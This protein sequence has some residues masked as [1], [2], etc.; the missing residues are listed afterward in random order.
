MANSFPFAE[1]KPEQAKHSPSIS[2]FVLVSSF[3]LVILSWLLFYWLPAWFVAL[4]VFPVLLLVSLLCW[5]LSRGWLQRWRIQT[6]RRGI[7]LYTL[8]LVLLTVAAPIYAHFYGIWRTRSFIQE[9]GLDV[10]IESQ[11]I[12]LLDTLGDVAPYRSVTTVY[13]LLEPIENAEVKIRSRLEDKD[14]WRFFENA[15]S[16]RV[17]WTSCDPRTGGPDD[18]LILNADGT[19]FVS[20][21]YASPGYCRLQ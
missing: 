18:T 17:V 11:E 12:V 10:Q 3:N 2:L 14:G 6:T 1:Q 8:A 20:L 16:G 13:T 4:Y 19:V 21:D 9:I 15:M 7:I 5:P